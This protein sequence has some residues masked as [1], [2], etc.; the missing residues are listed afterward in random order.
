M[1]KSFTIHWGEFQRSSLLVDLWVLFFNCIRKN[2]KIYLHVVPIGLRLTSAITNLVLKDYNSA[3]WH[4]WIAML[5]SNCTSSYELSNHGK[6]TDCILHD[7]ASLY[8]WGFFYLQRT[9]TL[10]GHKLLSLCHGKRDA[11]L[12]F[13]KPS[14]L[15]LYLISCCLISLIIIKYVF[16]YFLFN[17]VLNNI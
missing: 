14:Y 3:G 2:I 9:S 10:A 15:C 6:E 16:I 11:G 12:W 5:P 8:Q 4:C 7:N 1:T 17:K 13:V